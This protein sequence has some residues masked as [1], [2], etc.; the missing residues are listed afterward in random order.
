MKKAALV[1]TFILLSLVLTT[2]VSS[3]TTIDWWFRIGDSVIIKNIYTGEYVYRLSIYDVDLIN[4]RVILRLQAL[5]QGTPVSYAL[6]Q[7]ERLYGDLSNGFDVEPL[8]IF[9]GI[10]GDVSVKLRFYLDSGYTV[11]RD[12]ATLEITSDP[13][14]AEVYIDDEYVGRTP[15]TVTLLSGTHTVVIKKEGYLPYSTTL[16][17]DAGDVRTIHAELKPEIGWIRITSN[18]SGAD[19]YVDGEYRGDTPGTYEVHPGTHRIRIILDHYFEYSTTVEVAANETRELSVV[20]RPKP[21][22]LTV[23]SDPPGA[24]VYVNG[25]LLGKTPVRDHELAPGR[26]NIIVLKEG[27]EPYERNVTLNPDQDYSINAKLEYTMSRLVV[28]SEPEGASVF[29]NGELIGKTPTEKI[30]EPGT[31]EVTVS[32]EGYETYETDITLEKGEVRE[33]SLTLDAIGYLNIKSNPPG[34]DVYLNG[35]HI[36]RTPIE[37]YKVRAGEYRITLEKDGYLKY[38]TAVPIGPGDVEQITTELIPSTTGESPRAAPTN[39]V[40]STTPK[41]T[42]ALV[43]PVEASYN[44]YIVGI[45]GLTLLGTVLILRHRRK[46]D[47]L[48]L[49]EMELNSIHRSGIPEEARQIYKDALDLIR[50][51]R[52]TRRKEGARE[53][54][55]KLKRKLEELKRITTEYHSLKGQIEREIRGMLGVVNPDKDSPNEEG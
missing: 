55:E 15:L 44:R 16:T 48:K 50:E 54:R 22:R 6:Y 53:S 41:E 49:I 26:Y 14:D 35:E 5:P 3:E 31:Y 19:V 27:Y 45:L 13:D 21:A 32:L 36:G 51:I 33:L 47:E 9:V 43:P 37:N 52:N 4:G 7:N 42:V 34:A 46:P 25:D 29:V 28:K 40:E 30:L 11:I 1:L 20:L 10:S 24:E 39:N 2:P 12:A 8:D 17:L 18:P 38:E 23:Y